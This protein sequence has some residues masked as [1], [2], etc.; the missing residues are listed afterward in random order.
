MNS[1]GILSCRN[2]PLYSNLGN[3]KGEPVNIYES[4]TY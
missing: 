2:D 4:K 1:K 3:N